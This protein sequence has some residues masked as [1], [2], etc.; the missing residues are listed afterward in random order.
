MSAPQF[1][2]AH[3]RDLTPRPILAAR[4]AALAIV[5]AREACRDAVEA[6]LTDALDVLGDP[7]LT[8]QDLRDAGCWEGA[9]Q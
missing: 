1:E 8:V 5:A 6:F 2:P 9:E 3:F 7:E 4:E